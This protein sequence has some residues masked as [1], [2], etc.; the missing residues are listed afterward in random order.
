MEAAERFADI[1]PPSPRRAVDPTVP[2]SVVR[3]YELSEEVA[4]DALFFIQE[5]E[6]APSL[7]RQKSAPRDQTV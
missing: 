7:L 2:L 6:A 5:L 3:S 1:L 4:L